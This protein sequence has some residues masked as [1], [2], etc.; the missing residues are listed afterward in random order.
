MEQ[1]QF[2]EL[3]RGLAFRTSGPAA[4]GERGG[5][6]FSLEAAGPDI[7][8]LRTA[9]DGREESIR[10]QLDSWLAAAKAAGRITEYTDKDGS[11]TASL[12]VGGVAPADVTGLL[13]D[14]AAKLAE[15]G[16][17]SACFGCNTAVSAPPALVGST[18]LGMCGA[19]FDKAAAAAEA[20]RQ[21]RQMAPSSVARGFIGALAGGLVGSVA[22]ILL[23]VLGIYASI[24][25]LAIAWAA[26]TGYKLFK[27]GINTAAPIVIG[28]AV[29]VSVLF[30]EAAGIV[31]Q[32]IKAGTAQGYN[33]NV[34]DAVR[35]L[36]MMLRDGGTIASLLPN[37]GLG[38]LFA[39][40]G[41]WRLL[42]NLYRQGAAPIVDVRRP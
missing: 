27:G 4:W 35:V 38:L 25:G 15:L 2:E 10:L 30:G 20:V 22:W 7:L 29:L 24:A 31:I 41:S 18:A 6:W 14:L 37:L 1:A 9:V 21:Q 39:G 19:C 16:L 5:Y 26:I 12:P 17:R 32:I 36:P 8:K 28:A 13:D 3:A 11:V 34:G 42:R 33:L 23:G 40:L